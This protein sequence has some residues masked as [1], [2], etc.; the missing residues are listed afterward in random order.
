MDGLSGIEMGKL[1]G[2][3]DFDMS[4]RTAYVYAGVVV[5]LGFL[6]TRRVLSSPFGLA[7]RAL[8][9]NERRMPAL[10]VPVRRRL[11]GAYTLGAAL[12]GVAGGLSAQTTEF[13][14]LDVLSF[15]RSSAALIMLVLGGT[16]QLY[17][18]FVGTLAFMLLQNFF[19]GINPAYW[20]FWLGLLV[21][22]IAFFARGG[23]IGV[24]EKWLSRPLPLDPQAG[25]KGR[26]A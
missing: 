12:A 6:L 24:V 2:V 20:Q 22:S 21:V 26:G 18:A 25:A 4:G 15:E 1:F 7:L 8:R 19:S 9:E 23:L 3:W 14:S 13:V 11:V 17:G 10:G 16:G 5:F